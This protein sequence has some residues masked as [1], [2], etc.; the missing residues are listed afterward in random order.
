MVAVIY[1]GSGDNVRHELVCLVVWCL[2][3]ILS[4]VKTVGRNVFYGFLIN[5][6]CFAKFP[7]VV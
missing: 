2:H 3:V 5:V 4:A 7:H 1:S 6:A